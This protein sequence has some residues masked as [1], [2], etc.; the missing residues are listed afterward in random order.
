MRYGKHPRKPSNADAAGNSVGNPSPGQ[1]T[2]LGLWNIYVLP[3]REGCFYFGMLSIMLT[4]AINYSNSLIYGATFLLGG[5]AALCPLHAYK[6]LRG[7]VISITANPL[8]GF[9]GDSI[10][11]PI[12]LENP[13][14]RDRHAI[15]LQ[16]GRLSPP[17]RKDQPPAPVLIA[18]PA[19][20]R[21]S[22][23]LPVTAGKRGWL[24]LELIRIGT[25]YPLGLFRAWA[26]IP[27]RQRCLVYPRPEG[28]LPLPRSNPVVGEENPGNAIGVEDLRG[29]RPYQ[30][31][32]SPRNI[33]W[34]TLEGQEIL[35]KHFT[36][37]K[38]E[39]IILDWQH[40]ASLPGNEPRLSQLCLWLLDA[41]AKDSQYGMNLPGADIPPGQGNAHH[42]RC[43]A[44][45]ALFGV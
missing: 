8:P 36:K 14:G 45:L 30:P 4:C 39:K 40:V 44:A 41:E 1:R 9:A 19:G 34:N 10:S 29:F 13:R 15:Q 43:L 24:E 22:S 31:G 42:G 35:I 28:H 6:H 38:K 33:V 23:D 26:R 37:G 5:V 16:V 17:H 20:S 32:D 3:T 2:R 11:F 7:L 27:T 25:R 12:H 21:V 18:I